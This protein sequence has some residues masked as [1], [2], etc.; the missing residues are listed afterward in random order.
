MRSRS[1]FAIVLSSF[2][3]ASVSCLSQAQ[4]ADSKSE[5]KFDR[6]KDEKKE[7]HQ[8]QFESTS[9]DAKPVSGDDDT[10]GPDAVDTGTDDA[11]D[12]DDD[13]DNGGEEPT[14]LRDGCSRGLMMFEGVCTSKDKVDQILDRRSREALEKLQTAK[15]PKQSAEAAGYLIEQ[16]IA[17]MDKAED[18]LEE[19]IE[20][21]KEENAAKKKMK[22][23]QEGLL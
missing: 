22:K 17:Q 6:A 2:L 4:K 8:P 19:I 21:L 13:A 20:Q 16:N 7:E 12:A 18:D 11:D 5:S 1:Y 3:L 10:K 15:K 14:Y 23:E 9:E